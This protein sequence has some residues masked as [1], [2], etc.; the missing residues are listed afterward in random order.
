MKGL[1]FTYLATYGGA[2][3]S[4]FKPYYGLLIYVC[5]SI[6]RPE[7]LWYWAVTPGNYSRIVAVGLLIGWGLHGFGSWR[8]GRAGVVVAMLLLFWLWVLLS[9]LQAASPQAS[10]T[11]LE[12]FSKVVLPFMVGMTLID[13]IEKLK[14]LAWV[15][16]LSQGYVAY[17]LNL[18]YYGGFNRLQEIGFGGMDNNCVAIAMVTSTG[19][20][21]FLGLNAPRWWQ[22]AIAFVC[23]GLMTNSVMF[24]FSRGGLVGLLIMGAISFILIP[25]KP[26]HYLI[27]TLMVLLAIRLAG[28]EVMARFWTT[29]A[30][31]KARDTSAQSRVEMWKTCV[32]IMEKS[33]IFGI[34]P[35][36][37]PLVAHL[38]GY[39]P[40]KEAHTLWLQVGAE[41][42]AVGLFFLA[43]F[44]SVCLWRLWPLTR[45]KTPV[46][47]RWFR[48]SARMVIASI[49]GFAVSAQFV[50]LAGLELPYYVVL[51]GAATLKLM[52]QP[53]ATIVSQPA[54]CLPAPPRTLAVPQHARL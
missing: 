10:L 16:V 50:S 2:L 17:D 51:L 28:P 45:T 32:E 48:D 11:W 33:P 20:A 43:S 31:E 30:D 13:S 8:F 52:S 4:L 34:G 38:Y 9:G 19:V 39:T 22:T 1:I 24:A 23:A 3:A 40:L 44:Y 47:D 36:H 14:Q 15:M 5:F 41:T 25:K 6:I 26:R 29:F 18:A 37:F 35:R 21:L 53:C 12:S 54:E 27:F 42:G 7:D 49:T 46:A